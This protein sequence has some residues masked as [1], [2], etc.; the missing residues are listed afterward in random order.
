MQTYD[1]SANELTATHDFHHISYLI[2]DD[3]DDIMGR[4]KA[5]G[6]RSQKRFPCCL[7][8]YGYGSKSDSSI[9]EKVSESEASYII[10]YF[11][12]NYLLQHLH[13]GHN[14]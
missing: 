13:F 3:K 8:V 11:Y 6:L 2:E 14:M 1:E 4:T 7:Q 10:L 5:R 9:P 12:C